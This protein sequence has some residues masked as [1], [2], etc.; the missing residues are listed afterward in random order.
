MR[1]KIFFT[2]L[3]SLSCAF[4]WAAPESIKAI[5]SAL[6]SA[7]RWRPK[8]ME[9]YPEGQPS[10]VLFYEQMSAENEAPVKQVYFYPRVRSK[11]KWT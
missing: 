8:I 6:K 1:A 2:L 10:R 5:A 7:N 3:L 4:G 9:S 11:L